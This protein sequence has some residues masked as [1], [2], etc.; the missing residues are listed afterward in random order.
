MDPADAPL[1]G[2]QHCAIVEGRKG[3]KTSQR[4][5]RTAVGTKG[6]RRRRALPLADLHA[7]RRPLPCS[8]AM[9]EEGRWRWGEEGTT[10]VRSPPAALASRR[11][12]MGRDPTRCE[13]ELYRG[14]DRRELAGAPRQGREETGRARAWRAAGRAA[15]PPPP[16]AV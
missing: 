3:R 14:Y 16:R 9:G 10:R 2:S 6:G 11:L 8:G 4:G 5:A 1:I 13:L 7:R 12:N 15:R